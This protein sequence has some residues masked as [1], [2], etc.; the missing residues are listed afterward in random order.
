MSQRLQYLDMLTCAGQKYMQL[1]P[2]CRV[3]IYCSGCCRAFVKDECWATK[4]KKKLISAAL[5]DDL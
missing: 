4:E 3:M 1:V 5:K 2:C